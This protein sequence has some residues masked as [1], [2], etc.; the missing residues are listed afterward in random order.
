MGDEIDC[1]DCLKYEEK[2]CKEKKHLKLLPIAMIAMTISVSLYFEPI[3]TIALCGTIAIAIA[4]LKWQD[5]KG[6][7]IK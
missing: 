4:F 1:G 3:K 2:S 6:A 5:K 7:N